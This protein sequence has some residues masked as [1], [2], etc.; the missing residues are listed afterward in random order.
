MFYERLLDF[1]TNKDWL[2]YYAS[3]LAQVL[4]CLRTKS[5]ESWAELL[6]LLDFPHG[7]EVLAAGLQSFNE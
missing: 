6:E 1:V 2:N 7:H 4:S 3:F 5:A